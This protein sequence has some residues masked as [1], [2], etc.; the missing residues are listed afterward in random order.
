MTP[1]DILVALGGIETVIIDFSRLHAFK[2]STLLST[3]S[4]LIRRHL[5]NQLQINLYKTRNVAHS[6]ETVSTRLEIGTSPSVVS[7]EWA[8]FLSS[9]WRCFPP[10]P[11]LIVSS[12]SVL[13]IPFFFSECGTINITGSWGFPLS[14]AQDHCGWFVSSS[15][16]R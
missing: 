2:T 16:P 9:F 15:P 3:I 5:C 8:L 12:P 4:S 7:A 14:P 1:E 10:I 13:N 11:M 6:L